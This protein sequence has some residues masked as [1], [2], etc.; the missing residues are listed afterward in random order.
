MDYLCEYLSEED[1]KVIRFNMCSRDRNNF[2]LYEHNI[3]EVL[4][5]L[6]GIGVV[7]FKD[8]L[9]YR[10]DI[11]F[12]DVDVLR[13]EVNRINSKLMVYLFNNDVSNLI[14]LNI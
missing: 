8:I 3:R 4:D 1:F 9:L 11:C 13:D 12:K 5:Y 6:K 7:N 2:S 14:N 10:R